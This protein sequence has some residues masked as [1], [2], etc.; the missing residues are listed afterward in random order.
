LQIKDRKTPNVSDV[1]IRK[2]EKLIEEREA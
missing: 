1:D 2:R